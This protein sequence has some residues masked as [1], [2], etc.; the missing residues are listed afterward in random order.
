MTKEEQL[1]EDN[2]NMAYKVA[3]K[4]IAKSGLTGVA[5]DIRQESLIGLWKACNTFDESLGYKFSTHA[6]S[7][8]WG[9]I[10]KSSTHL[11]TRRERRVMKHNDLK[12][13]KVSTEQ[14]VP[15]E[16]K[17]LTLGELLESDDAYTMETDV[18]N[19]IDFENFKVS[20]DVDDRDRLIID[21][22][23]DD[24][25]QLQIS[26]VLGIQQGHVSR[27]IYRLR[28]KYKKWLMENGGTNENKEKEKGNIA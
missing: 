11:T 28:I 3:H 12:I 27:I 6:Y 13:V 2:I 1:F 4:F 8:S 5:E 26:D 22:M 7:C 25:T 18:I 16:G 15:T 23:I 21:M 24:R 20:K 10:M 9:Q 19:N 17:K 14:I